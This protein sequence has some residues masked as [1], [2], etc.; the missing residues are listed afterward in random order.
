VTTL[1]PLDVQ[2]LQTEARVF[3]DLQLAHDEPTLYAVTDGKAVGTYLEKKFRSY[4]SER[5]SLT[6]GNAALGVDFPSVNVDLKATSIEKP[7]SSCPYQSARQKVFG[8]GYSLL[9][10]VYDKQDDANTKTARLTIVHVVFIEAAATGDY[11][12]TKRLRQMVKDGANVDDI[13]AYL[14]DRNLPG[15]EDEAARI[16]AEVLQRP[17]EQGALTISNALQWR[18]KYGH[19]IDEA[20]RLPGVQ[21][22]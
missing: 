9:V 20:G 19:A 16:A 7:Q 12:L 3:A 18:L 2:A 8:L 15:G 1:P 4:L 14:T 22:L 10:L 21:S 5:F 13:V 6:E 17:P 11:T